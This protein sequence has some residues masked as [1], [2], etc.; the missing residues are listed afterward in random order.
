TFSYDFSIT[1]HSV[2]F[3]WQGAVTAGE[4]PQW[5]PYQAFGYPMSLNLQ[6]GLFYPPLW[7]F[8]IT[9]IA[10]S[11]RAAA[12]LQ[13]LHILACPPGVYPGQAVACLAFAFGYLAL[14][15]LE[16][17]LD[18]RV[19]ASAVRAAASRAGAIIVGLG[20]SAVSVLPGWFQRDEISR[21][22]ETASLT[23]VH[24]DL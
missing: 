22:E 18:H 13:C 11:V 20:L 7:F 4:L 14:Q 24:A 23:R 9:G 16:T 10:Y 19:V 15:I 17:R 21:V 6:S 2:P 12:I 5:I 8:P 3:Y 1:Y